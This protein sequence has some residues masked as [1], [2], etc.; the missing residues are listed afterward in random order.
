MTCHSRT[1][2]PD[3]ISRAS[4]SCRVSQ[5]KGKCS[6][7]QDCPRTASGRR[8]TPRAYRRRIEA[9]NVDT[10]SERTPPW[11]RL[12]TGRSASPAHCRG[13]RQRGCWIWRP[14]TGATG[15][16]RRGSTRHRGSGSQRG[17]R[18][19]SRNGE[20]RIEA[21]TVGNAPHHRMASRVPAKRAEPM[22]PDLDRVY[23]HP[24]RRIVVRRSLAEQAIL[25]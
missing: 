12:P 21:D 10:P 6:A 16:I 4:C 7:M 8:T 25:P 18:T 14:C 19:G 17:R 23:I 13:S 9:R 1:G 15:S 22:N 20:R 24:P 11:S 5:P 3:R 2:Q